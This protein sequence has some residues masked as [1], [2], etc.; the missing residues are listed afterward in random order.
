MVGVILFE[1]PDVH[2]LFFFWNGDN[3]HQANGV[4]R[5][6]I[7]VPLRHSKKSKI[8]KLGTLF[9]WF[10]IF[11]LPNWTLGMLS[12]VS[13]MQTRKPIRYVIDY[14]DD[15]RIAMELTYTQ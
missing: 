11:K 15:Q 4:T 2:S 3:P 12:E 1:A 7:D 14:G 13:Q 6:R 10:L 8:S 5:D 9:I